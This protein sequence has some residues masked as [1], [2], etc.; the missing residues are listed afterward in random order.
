MEAGYD[1]KAIRRLLKSKGWVKVRVGAYTFPDLWSIADVEEQHLRRAFAIARKLG[2]RVALSHV[3]AALVHGLSVWNVDLGRVHVTR[4]DA[5]AGRIEAGVV[6]HEGLTQP[7]DLVEVNGVLV[8]KPSRAAL[9]T[10][11]LTTGE[12]GLV[13][14]DSVMHK[15][16]CQRDELE[17]TYRLMGSW[18]DTRKLLVPVRMADGRAESVGESRWRHLCYSHGIPRPELQYD[19]F[20]ADGRLIGTCDM[21]WPDH[22]LL[23]EFDGKVKY[24]RLLRPGEEPGD[25]VFREKHREDA[26]R[27]A[28]RWSMVRIIWADFHRAAQTAARIWRLLRIAA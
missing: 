8:M 19:V 4:L 6:H 27:E 23:G 25:A 20:D 22:G 15:T 3:T 10:A 2:D 5:G 1:D 12:G 24:G 14:L 13:V 17:A 21:A 11:M 9:E 16:A 18:A 28:T 7:E 26:L